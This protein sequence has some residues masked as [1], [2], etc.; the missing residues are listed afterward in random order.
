MN[1]AAFH[2]ASRKELQ[3]AEKRKGFQRQKREGQGN[4]KQKKQLFQA[5]L[6]SFGG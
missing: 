6:P 4:H 3:R 2:L 1:Q 5:R